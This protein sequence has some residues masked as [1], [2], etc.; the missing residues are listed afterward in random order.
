[1]FP[2]STRR[3]FLKRSTAAIG[4]TV[5]SGLVRSSAAKTANEKIVVGLIGCGGRGRSV[6]ALFRNTPG[7]ELAY[8]C[9]VDESRRGKAAESLG[10]IAGNCVGDL[11]NALEENFGCGPYHEPFPRDRHRA[12]VLPYNVSRRP[13]GKKYGPAQRT[14]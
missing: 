11:R 14:N 3:N 7:V 12:A 8:V 5:A 10:V 13:R 4:A 9:D 2:H 6:A 1:M